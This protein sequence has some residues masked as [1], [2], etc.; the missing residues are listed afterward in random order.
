M[1][2]SQ[3]LVHSRESTGDV[4][5]AAEDDV[6]EWSVDMRARGAEG[7]KKR[8]LHEFGQS[9]PAIARAMTGYFAVLT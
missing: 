6:V 1:R 9:Y 3:G 8:G 5:V 4:A 7:Q 2:R